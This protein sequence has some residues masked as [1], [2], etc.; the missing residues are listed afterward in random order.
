MSRGG[1]VT[2]GVKSNNGY[3]KRVREFTDRHLEDKPCLVGTYSGT[4]KA[5]EEAFDRD[6]ARALNALGLI[7]PLFIG[8]RARSHEYAI[9]F[10]LSES[11]APANPAMSVD[12]DGRTTQLHIF[13]KVSTGETSVNRLAQ[14]PLLKSRKLSAAGCGGRAQVKTMTI[15]KWHSLSTG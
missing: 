9:R 8:D 5:V 4:P 12:V 11:S 1:D 15:R 6:S 13:M 14:S 10:V 7:V 3:A 2:E